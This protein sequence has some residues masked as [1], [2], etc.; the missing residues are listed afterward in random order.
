MPTTYYCPCSCGLPGAQLVRAGFDWGDC[1]LLQVCE[2]AGWLCSLCL[3]H[4]SGIRGT[5]R[6]CGSHG[7]DRKQ[8]GSRNTWSLSRSS[9]GTSTLPLWA[10]HHW[11]KPG[12]W[13]SP[14]SQV[15]EEQPAQRD[16]RAKVKM[17]RRGGIGAGNSTY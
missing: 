12:P 14:D 9:L 4:P 2:S 1:L 6:A 5:G 16:T 17:L 3:S 7:A 11:P 13:L 15:R 10:R 8:Q